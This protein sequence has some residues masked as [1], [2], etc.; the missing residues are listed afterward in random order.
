MAF[1]VAT[2]QEP[3]S[4]AGSKKRPWDAFTTTPGQK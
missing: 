1:P 2:S 4:L 3:C